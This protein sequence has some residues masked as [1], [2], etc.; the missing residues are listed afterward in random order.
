MKF[1]IA[2]AFFF[3]KILPIPAYYFIA[4]GI[5]LITYY[6]IRYRRDVVHENIARSFPDFDKEK[7]RSTEK[8]F[9]RHLSDYFVESGAIE[10][11]NEKMFKKRFVY[12]NAEVLNQY[13]TS[14]KNILILTGHYAN[15][16]WLCTLPFITSKPVYA[17]YKPQSNRF[18]DESMIR[19]REKY[20]MHLMT[21]PGIYKEVISQSIEKT[22]TVLMVADQRPEWEKKAKWIQF[23][24]QPITCFRGLENIHNIMKGVV[25]YAKIL[26]VKRGHYTVEF[27]PLKDD[28]LTLSAGQSLTEKYFRELEKNIHTA[29][30]YYLWSHKRWK[31]NKPPDHTP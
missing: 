5:F 23:M 27:I 7:I 11:L 31:F 14:G 12:L 22:L 20:G 28:T 26:K 4:N 18:F 15:W 9:Y 1:L 24:N 19:S 16:E 17:V 3:L 30:A 13:R 29:P 21:Y 2:A 6:V 8:E 25:V 10:R